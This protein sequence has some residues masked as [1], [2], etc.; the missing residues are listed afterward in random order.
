MGH[1]QYF[2]LSFSFNAIFVQ[3]NTKFGSYITHKNNKTPEGQW[4]N[5]I[6]GLIFLSPNEVGSYF[7]DDFMSTIPAN[8][9]F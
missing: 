7:V 4:L 8:I 1:R 9:K 6:F 5:N 3:K 2:W